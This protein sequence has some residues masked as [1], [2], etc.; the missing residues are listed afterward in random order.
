M[1]LFFFI[2]LAFLTWLIC[3]ELEQRTVQPSLPGGRCGD[4]GGEIQPDWLI[5][6]R[7]RNL[8]QQHC[9]VCGEAHACS[10]AY[11]PWCGKAVRE[12]AA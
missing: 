2:S 9:P 12:K 4:C 7:C 1:I 8:V 10:D 11:C 3:R 6:P 5:C